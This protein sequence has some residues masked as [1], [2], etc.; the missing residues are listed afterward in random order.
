MY[1]LTENKNDA[2]SF[3]QVNQ[4]DVWHWKPNAERRPFTWRLSRWWW[5]FIVWLTPQQRSRDR[6]SCKEWSQNPHGT[7]GI[8]QCPWWSE[9]HVAQIALEKN[10]IG[11]NLHQLY[12][13]FP[14]LFLAM[15]VD[16]CCSLIS[17][18]SS[19]WWQIVGFL[20]THVTLWY[21]AQLFNIK[22][23]IYIFLY[24]NRDLYSMGLHRALMMYSNACNEK[25]YKWV[26]LSW[27]W[28]IWL[29]TDQR[30]V[31]VY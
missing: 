22:R 10:Y 14:L 28:E 3:L 30:N 17:G 6:I 23:V 7:N 29:F 31:V 9:I 16:Y 24:K 2:F 19:P 11:G 18:S 8:T 13:G 15:G 21:I 20:I 26:I 4:S 12:L 27:T 1:K 5:R 25:S